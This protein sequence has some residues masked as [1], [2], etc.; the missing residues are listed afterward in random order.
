V[1]TF[2]LRRLL[3]AIVALWGVVTIV[4]VLMRLSGDPVPLMLPPDAPRSE[5]FR[6]RAELGLDQPLPLQY[7][8]FLANVAHGD[9]GRSIHMRMPALQLA[10]ERLD[11]TIQLAL[12]SFTIAVLIALPAGLVSALKRDTLWDHSLMSLA[13]LGQAAPTFYIGIMLILVLGLQL[14]LLPIS[15]RGGW[16]NLVMPAITL[17]AFAMASIARL[18][19][20]A[21]LDVSRADFIRTARAKGLREASILT[22]HNLKNAAIPIVTIM[23]LQFGTLLGG[24]VVTE[25]VFSWPGIGRLAIQSIYNRDYP[26]VQSAV[27]LMACSV[28]LVNF[29]VD[30]AYGWLDPRIRYR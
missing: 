18:T 24:A 23:G 9:L 8:V 1:T 4:F 13:L 20:S 11:A 19:R 7:A 21:V 25:T 27:L 2:L 6:V 26:V 28:I 14:G 5:I 17:G 10:A 16:Q 12:A 29:L 30:L 15:G 22:G 3:R